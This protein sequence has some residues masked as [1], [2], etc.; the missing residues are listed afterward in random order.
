[1]TNLA[2]RADYAETKKKLREELNKWMH[3]TEDPRAKGED[4]RWDKYPYFGPGL[5]KK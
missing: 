2:E 5:K 3:D 1:L 4:D